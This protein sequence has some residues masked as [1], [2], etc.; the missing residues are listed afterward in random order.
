MQIK[1]VGPHAEGVE[2]LD[3]PDF[4]VVLRDQPIDVPDDVAASLL[5]QE[6]NWAEVK[7]APATPKDK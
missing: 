7:A 6:T 5:Q 1:Y 3:L 2:V 4:P